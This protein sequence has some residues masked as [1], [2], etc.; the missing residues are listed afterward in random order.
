MPPRPILLIPRHPPGGPNDPHP[1][2]LR[3]P[4][5]PSLALDQ[6]LILLLRAFPLVPSP[7]TTARTPIRI[8]MMVVMIDRNPPILRIS[9]RALQPALDAGDEV[10]VAIKGRGRGELVAADVRGRV[11]DAGALRPGLVPL[12][13]GEGAGAGEAPGAAVFGGVDVAVVVF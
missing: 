3:P 2:P 1:R 5:E 13:A 6:M 7:S 4:Q 10:E 9:L 8:L 12:R 11:A